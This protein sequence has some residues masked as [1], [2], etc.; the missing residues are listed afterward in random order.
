MYLT[1]LMT[2]GTHGKKLIFSVVDSHAPLKKI[3]VKKDISS[4]DVGKATGPDKIS[5]KLLRMVAP[6]IARSLTSLLNASIVHGSFP[7]DWKESK[8]LCST[9]DW[10]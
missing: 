8:C 10:G 5:A 9:E 1:A 3:R 7:S 2:N 6:A 4:L